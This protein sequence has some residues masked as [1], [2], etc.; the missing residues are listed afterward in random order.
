MS[1]FPFK[2]NGYTSK[3]LSKKNSGDIVSAE[4]MPNAVNFIYVP[5]HN[6]TIIYNS[7]QIIKAYEGKFKKD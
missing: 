1:Q 4:T 6:T 7:S 2:E 5:V 3:V